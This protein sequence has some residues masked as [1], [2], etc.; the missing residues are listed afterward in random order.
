MSVCLYDADT[1]EEARRISSSIKVHFAELQRGSVG[2]L[3]PP[4]HNIETFLDTDMLQSV[5]RNMSCSAIGSLQTVTES[6]SKMINKYKPDEI[7]ISSMI[8]NPASRINSLN[9]AANAFRNIGIPMKN[10]Y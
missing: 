10:N 4:I 2:K 8:Y 9:I 6:L 1:D 3:E 7:M 5:E